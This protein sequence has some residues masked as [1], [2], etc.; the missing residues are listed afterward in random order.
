MHALYYA[1]LTTLLTPHE[2]QDVL[3]REEPV[4]I[5]L[6]HHRQVSLSPSCLSSQEY[7]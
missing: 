7:N 2:N 5:D 1:K 6:N 3:K 4:L